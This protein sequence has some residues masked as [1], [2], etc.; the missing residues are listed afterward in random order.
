MKGKGL[1]KLLLRDALQRVLDLSSSIGIHA[2]A[3]HAI[4]DEAKAFYEKFGLVAL[5]DESQH[6]YLP[7]ST[8]AK[9]VT[10]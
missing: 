10:E 2:I 9:S 1:G 7:L 3:V 8:I 6:L 5:S 4:D